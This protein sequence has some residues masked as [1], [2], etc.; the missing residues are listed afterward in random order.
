MIPMSFDNIRNLKNT[1]TI[2]Y[3]SKY[4][5]AIKNVQFS[6][7]KIIF[8]KKRICCYEHTICYYATCNNINDKPTHINSGRLSQIPT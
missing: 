6:E 2:I 3:K 5:L 7:G 1:L 8:L 4:L